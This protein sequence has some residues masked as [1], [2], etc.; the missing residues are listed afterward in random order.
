MPTHKESS[1]ANA[2]SILVLNPNSS[3]EVTQAIESVVKSFDGLEIRVDQIDDAPRTIESSEDHAVVVPLVLRR[4]KEVTEDVVIIACHGDPGVFESQQSGR[5][6]V[7]GIGESSMLVACAL[8]GQFGIIT[9]GSELIARKWAQVERYRL[10][11]RCAGVVASE[12]GV[13][14]GLSAK[15]IIDPYIDAG[16]RLIDSGASSIILGCAGM[17]RAQSAVQDKLG[18]IVIDPIRAAIGIT[19]GLP[20]HLPAQ[21]Y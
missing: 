15:P 9:L 8:G 1:T 21:S 6:R 16:R 14:H 10:N 5:P 17:T 2:S 19:L 7:I 13:L 12:T 4:L 20:D 3:S 11:G 18:V